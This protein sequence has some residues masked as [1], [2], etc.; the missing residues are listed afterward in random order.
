MESCI[1]T[2]NLAV[3]KDDLQLRLMREILSNKDL[4]ARLGISQDV[5]ASFLLEP[6]L[7]SRNEA[8]YR[9]YVSP[10]LPWVENVSCDRSVPF[11][12]RQPLGAK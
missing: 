2:N 5:A 10:L 3:F 1:N 11:L 7:G 9:L 8:F 6:S 12:L 4:S